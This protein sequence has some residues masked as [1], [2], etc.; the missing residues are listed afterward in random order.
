MSEKQ[1]VYLGTRL[2]RLR[3]DLGLTQADMAADLDI[4]PSYIALM[5]RNQRPI[6]A[7]VLLRLARSYK[8]DMADLAGD[9]GADHAARLQTVMKDPIFGDIDFAATEISD[10]ASSFP[11]FSEA[12]LRLYTAYREEQLAFADYRPGQRGTTSE[13]SD[14]VAATRRF[15]AARRNSFPAL[16]TA[17]ERLAA[18]VSEKNGI[19]SY[20]AEKHGLRV[21]RLPTSAMS[22]MVRRHDLHRK[23]IL[24]D[25]TLDMASQQFQLAQQLAYLE[26]GAEITAAV[27]EGNFQSEASARLTH[28]ALAS[29]C[30]AA[31]L[32]PYSA[33]AKAV[34]VKRYDLAALARQFGTSFEQTAHRLTT[35]QKPGQERI[36]FFFIRL[37]SAGNVSK[38][39]D[40]AQF[41]FSAY[42]GGCPLWNVHQ[43][44]RTPGEII[45]QWLEFPDGQRFFSI[46]RTVSTGGGAYSAPRVDRAVA[47]VCD[48]QHADRLV[49]VRPESDRTPVPVGVA[50]RLCQRATCTSRA[51]PPIGRQILIDD[52][53]RTAA[54]FGFAD[55]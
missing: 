30:A 50:C 53:R 47:L 11:A 54:P 41:P 37:D 1:G 32:M 26:F 36:P 39:L 19:A 5:E 49:Y 14:P 48:A 23:Q 15:L 20:L 17:A 35:L 46:A 40:G 27:R 55:T 16:D 25:E 7:E 6:T 22:D 43:V 38:R 24:L 31:L 13:A 2:R 10:I 29:Y 44:F 28:R 3:R 51:E 21:R 8:I 12:L 18:L 34:D 45:T 42:G 33:F 4:S 52:Y 9:G